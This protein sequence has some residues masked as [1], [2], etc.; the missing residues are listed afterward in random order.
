MGFSSTSAFG[1]A[2]RPAVRLISVA[3][4]R[5]LIWEVQQQFVSDDCEMLA[6][7]GQGIAT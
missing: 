4:M 2:G 3:C 5:K 7:I 6:A 1:V